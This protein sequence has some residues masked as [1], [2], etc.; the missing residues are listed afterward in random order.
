MDKQTKK[1]LFLDILTDNQNLREEINRK[2]YGGSTYAEEMRKALGLTDSQFFVADGTKTKLPN[3]TL[4]SAIVMGGSV[5]DPVEGKEK[6]WMKRVYKF[7]QKAYKNQVPI[8]GICG[9]LQFTIRALGGEIIYNPK[10]RNF[11][12]S[13]VTLSKDGRKD[14]LFKG[15]PEQI[16][17]QSS[18]K[19]IAKELKL[20]WR[21]LASS[22]K[23]P[24]DA[25]AIGDN[26]R[27]VQFHP[28][29]KAAHAKALVKMRKKKLISEGFISEKDFPKLIKSFKDTSKTGKKLLK[30]FLSYFVRT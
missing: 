4:Y 2:V 9:G 20:G 7:I 29:M 5:E 10:G 11:G 15:L 14:L 24:I 6:P 23:S 19:C 13:L 30:N 3:S 28:E 22:E 16:F 18:H 21:L 12:N 25:V 17:V 8:L 1:I 27:L 26:I